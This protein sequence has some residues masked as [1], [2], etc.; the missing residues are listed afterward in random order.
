MPILNYTTT[1]SAEKTV[2][3]I[4][5]IL[6]KSGAKEISY[7]QDG[8]R[9]VAVKFQIDLDGEPLWF[10]MEPNPTGVLSAM[11]RDRVERRFRNLDHARRVGWRIIKNAIDSQMAIVLSKQGDVTQV[12]L[13]YAIDNEG[14]GSYGVF[15]ESRQKLLTAGKAA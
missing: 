14:R 2:G 5:T 15:R 4:Y 11:E 7:E 3:E 1:V 13:P 9:V 12:F 10:R 6:A 8:E